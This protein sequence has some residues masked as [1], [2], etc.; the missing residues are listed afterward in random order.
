MVEEYVY[1]TQDGD[2]YL[3]THG[4]RHSEFSSGSWKQ[5]VFNKGYELITPLSLF[6][7]KI[8]RFSLVYALKNTIRGKRY[9][10]QY[11]T[12]LANYC[13]QKGD[14]KGIIVGHIHHN[15]MRKID[16]IEYMCC[17][18]FVD[19]NNSNRGKE[20]IFPIS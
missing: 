1:K 3:C 18:D 12:D 13:R 7:E 9:I 8:F 14:Y 19:L 2:K 6:L 11:E 16:K 20:W 17:G 4:D 10:N 5:L 15:N